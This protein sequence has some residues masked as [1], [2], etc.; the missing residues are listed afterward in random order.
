MRNLGPV[1]LRRLAEIGVETEEDL[2][3][4]GAA[5]AWRRLRFAFGKDVTLNA[6]YALQA[7]LIGSDWRDLPEETRRRLRAIAAEY[8]RQSERPVGS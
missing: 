8:K 6:L 4:M 7:A 1:T 5:E 2:R 3:R